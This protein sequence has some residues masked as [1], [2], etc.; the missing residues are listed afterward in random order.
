MPEAPRRPSAAAV[1]GVSCLPAAAGGATALA[2]LCWLAVAVAGPS[3]AVPGLGPGVLPVDLG[4]RPSS[5]LVSALLA[6]SVLAGGVAVL[7]GLTA[8]ARGWRPRRL[9]LLAATGAVATALVPPVGSADHLSYAAYGRIAALGADPYAEPPDAFAGGA[10]PVASAVRDP[11]RSTTSVYG[12]VGTAVHALTSLVGGESVRATVWCWQLVLLVA[13]AAVAAGLHVA[14]RGQPALRAR[15]HVLWTANPLLLTVGLGGAHADVLAG[16]GA[17]GVLLLAPRYPFAAGAALAVA[18][19]TKLPYG[20]VGAGVLV[21]WWAA[22]RTGG[23]GT[24]W[25]LRG[26]TGALVLLVPAHLWAGAHAYDQARTAS[27]Y[28]SLATVWRPLVD[29][30]VPR[31]VLLPGTLALMA[32]V[33]VLWWPLLVGRARSLPFSPG[34]WRR[35]AAG[36]TAVLALG[37][38]LAAPYELPWYDLLL[39]GPLALAAA[40]PAGVAGGWLER[41]VAV[42]L[43]LLALAYVPGLVDGMSPAV[44]AVTLGYRREVGPWVAWSALLTALALGVALRRWAAAGARAA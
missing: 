27:R 36:V 30:G 33:A 25:L 19:G 8:V 32:V 35:C 7:T 29:A 39:W 14:L 2:L 6:V 10:D 1:A 41:V 40:A 5:A 43:T 13:W 16:A 9:L 22:R 11:W 42:R 18:V 24:G 44:E 34:R 37:Y 20:A 31:S 38:L 4:L 28:V 26:L 15:A 17:V 23:P 3:A 21:A 12:P